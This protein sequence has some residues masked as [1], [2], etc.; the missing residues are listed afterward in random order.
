MAAATTVS[1]EHSTGTLYLDWHGAFAGFTTRRHRLSLA[2]NGFHKLIIILAVTETL[3]KYYYAVLVV[4][5]FT[6]VNQASWKHGGH[7]VTLKKL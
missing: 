4:S 7:L 2:A 5:R 6:D 3:Q 1:S